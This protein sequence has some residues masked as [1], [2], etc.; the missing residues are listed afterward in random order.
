MVW[1][2]WERWFLDIEETHTS[3]PAVVFFRSPQP[4][5]SWAT[6]A[7]AVL[8]GAALTLSTV[9]VERDVQAEFCLRAGY[10]CLRRIADSFRIPYDPTRAPTIRSRS[11]E[12]S[13]RK[14]CAPSRRR[15]CPSR[16]TGTRRGGTSPGGA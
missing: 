12:T 4:D 11:G 3:F 14:P 13:G 16:P 10:L 7:G 15:G 6:A 5:H 8:D 2:E 1:E 9:D